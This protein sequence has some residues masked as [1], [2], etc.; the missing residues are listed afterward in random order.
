MR[1]QE[2]PT[3]LKEFCCGYEIPEMLNHL[4]H[5]NVERHSTFVEVTGSIIFGGG[6]E[7]C[8]EFEEGVV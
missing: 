6:Y 5:V 4:Y 8:P 1:A 7:N 3:T 2:Y